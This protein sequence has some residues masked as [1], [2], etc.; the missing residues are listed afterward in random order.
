MSLRH[1]TFALAAL[2]AVAC[3]GSPD[4]T[5]DAAGLAGQDASVAGGQDASTPAGKDAA[6]PTDQDGAVAG[7]DSSFPGDASLAGL[8]AQAFAPD[9]GPTLGKISVADLHAILTGGTKDFLLIN[10]HEPYQGDIAGTDQDIVYTDT[11]AL[12]AYIGADLDTRVVVYCMSN[13]MSGI[14]GN[15]LVAR[16]YRAIRYLDGG[17]GAWKNA[18]Y[19]F[20]AP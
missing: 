19:P 13:Y 3:S 16:G 10:V 6:S 18:G 20:Q 2:L 1:T 11:N 7:L 4:K 14:A 8:D 12:A 17:M 15:A 5:S 9:A